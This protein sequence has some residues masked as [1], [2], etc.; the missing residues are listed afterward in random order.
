MTTVDAV[1]F[2]YGFTLSSE[3]YFNI[4]HP[5]IAHWREVI[6]ESVFS[7]ESVTSDWMRGRISLR[8]IA[9]ILQNRT[10]EDLESILAYLRDGCRKLRENHAVVSLAWKLKEHA[11]PIGL[12]TVN[13]DV[14]SDIIVPEHRYDE[15]FDVI[16]N[17]CDHGETDKRVLWPM[18]FAKL[19]GHIGYSNCLLIEDGEKNPQRFREAGGHAIQ[20]ADDA[21]FATDISTLTIA[22]S[23]FLRSASSDLF[24][25]DGEVAIAPGRHVADNA[26]SK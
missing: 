18:A 2:D 8:E 14:F 22:N 4:P 7:S 13:F 26:S 21:T 5:R 15:L 10:G 24:P 6:Q 3:Y 23:R 12:V 25:C 20:Y 17:S 1:I 9:K 11:I 16:V 19:G